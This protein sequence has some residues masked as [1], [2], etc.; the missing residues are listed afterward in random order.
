[1]HSHRTLC[2]KRQFDRNPT[3]NFFLYEHGVTPAA[4][5]LNIALD[6]DRKA[7]GKAFGYNVSCIEDFTGLSSGYT[8]QQ[9]YMALHGQI[10][11]TPISGPNDIFNRYLTEDAYCALAPWSDIAKQVGVETPVID[12]VINI[13]NIIHG[14]DW[15]KDG[16]SAEKL[17]ISGMNAGQIL[18]YVKEENT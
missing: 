7:L 8:W 12:S 18:V 15:R 13:Y 10:S 17:G 9:L 1:M 4:A 14:K 5:K 11:L 6:N 2:F 3:I 16:Y